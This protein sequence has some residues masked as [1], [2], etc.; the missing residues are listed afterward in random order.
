MSS[1]K[2]NGT[3][4]QIWLKGLSFAVPLVIALAALWGTALNNRMDL[5]ATALKDIIA[6]SRSFAKEVSEQRAINLSQEV[7]F[8]EIKSWMVRLEVKLD[9]V[10]ERK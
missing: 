4:F 9:R 7:Q 6:E 5:I 1:S 10:L 2:L 3:F 8:A